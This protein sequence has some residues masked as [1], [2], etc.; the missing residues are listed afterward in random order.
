MSFT[1]PVSVADPVTGTK[2]TATLLNTWRSDMEYLHGPVAGCRLRTNVATALGGG[3]QVPFELED[4]DNLACHSTSSN[5]TRITVPSNYAGVWWFGF[6]LRTTATATF[7]VCLNGTFTGA[8]VLTTA[9]TYSSASHISSALGFGSARLAV[10]DY[11]ELRGGS[12]ISTVFQPV[13]WA[14]WRNG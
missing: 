4:Y 11:I 12:T 14:H 8:N 7:T 9:S 2:A 5:T 6:C 3:G 1:D 13:F 10:G